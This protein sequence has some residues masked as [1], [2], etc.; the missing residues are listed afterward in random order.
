MAKSRQLFLLL[1]QVNRFL[2]EK[3]LSRSSL[4]YKEN[5]SLFVKG[6]RKIQKKIL[7]L[8]SPNSREPKRVM[9]WLHALW[10][11]RY[12]QCTLAREHPQNDGRVVGIK[13]TALLLRDLGELPRENAAFGGYVQVTPHVLGPGLLPA[14]EGDQHKESDI[15]KRLLDKQVVSGNSVYLK[16]DPIL[17]ICTI[18]Y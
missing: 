15:L 10:S 17:T 6:L 8:Q 1:V 18:C 11:H 2:P 5:S 14:S 13:P 7:Q 16:C 9:V 12:S 4:E 3:I